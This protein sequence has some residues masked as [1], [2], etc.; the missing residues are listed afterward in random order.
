LQHPIE[1]FD[2]KVVLIDIST[3]TLFQ[4]IILAG[5]S[6]GGVKNT[7]PPRIY[8]QQE[9]KLSSSDGYRSPT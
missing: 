2:L 6:A 4:L 7:P 5:S 8:L 3:E 1:D 9:E